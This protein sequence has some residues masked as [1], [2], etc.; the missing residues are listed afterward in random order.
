V[1]EQVV[2]VLEQQEL[3]EVKIL[4][5]IMEMK[6]EVQI[7]WLQVV[8]HLHSFNRIPISP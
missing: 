2:L 1:E 5:M 3:K 7:Q 6:K 4:E 8:I